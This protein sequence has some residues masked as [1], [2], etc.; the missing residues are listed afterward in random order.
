[1][2][3]RLVCSSQDQAGHIQ[4]LAGGISVVYVWDTF[5]ILSQSLSAPRLASHPGG[6]EILVTLL[7]RNQIKLRPDGSL[8]LNADFTTGMLEI[9]VLILYNV[10]LIS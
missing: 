2:A 10:A 8:G 6:K 1:M 4:A 9:P 3:L 5:N 7:F